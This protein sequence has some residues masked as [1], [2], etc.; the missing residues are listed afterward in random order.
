VATDQLEQRLAV[1]FDLDR[2]D[3]RDRQEVDT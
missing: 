2:T 1:P 3:A